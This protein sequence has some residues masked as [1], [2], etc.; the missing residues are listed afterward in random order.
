M[1]EVSCSELRSSRNATGI[2][3]V[4]DGRFRSDGNGGNGDALS[5]IAR[6]SSSRI[7][8]S[9]ERRISKFDREPSGESSIRIVASPVM[10][11]LMARS[12]YRLERASRD[13]TAS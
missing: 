3:R 12:G 4:R 9:V 11:R 5:T 6:S 13:A 8:D 1:P 7:E 2:T 10:R